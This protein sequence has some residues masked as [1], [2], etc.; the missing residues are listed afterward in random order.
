MSK[1]TEHH[2][3]FCQHSLVFKGNT[4]RTI[5]WFE[6]TFR[7]FLRDN[8]VKSVTK[9]DRVLLEKWIIGKRLE[10][11]WSARTVKNRL[12]TLKLF[13]DWCVAQGLMSENPVVG[14]PIPK[15]PKDL[16][17]S[18]SVHDAKALLEWVQFMDFAFDFEQKRAAVILALFMFTGIRRQELLN[19]HL[20]HVCLTSEQIFVFVGKGQKD[21]RIPILPELKDA[22]EVYLLDR[23]RLGRKCSFL[24][25]PTNRDRQMGERG[26]VRLVKKI[27][28]KSGIYFTPHMLRHTFATL[29]LEGGCDIYALSKMMGHSD[30]KT[31]TIYLSATTE[32]LRKQIVHHPLSENSYS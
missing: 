12:C 29:M 11:N 24:L 32:H 31:T 16:P 23:K 15:P 13:F 8:P 25:T 26:I 10:K 7:Q 1:I 5:R 20:D 4:P 19:L 27:R 22:L 18:L 28:E 6:S 17:R 9:I 14:I 3:Q 21:R 2:R 30:I